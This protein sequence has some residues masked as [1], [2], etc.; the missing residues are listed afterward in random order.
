MV[1]P[2]HDRMPSIL[3][4]ADWDAWLSRDLPVP[5]ALPELL[6]PYPAEELEAHRVSEVVNSP[7]NEGPQCQERVEGQ[8]TKGVPLELFPGE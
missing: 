8:L 6:R 1:A 7:R 3:R 5:E 4:R 2:V